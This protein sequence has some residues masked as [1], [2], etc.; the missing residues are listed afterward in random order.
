MWLRLGGFVTMACVAACGG[1]TNSAAP[2]NNGAMPAGPGCEL[3]AP[4]G[5]VILCTEYVGAFSEAGEQSECAGMAAGPTLDSAVP[6]GRWV[7][8]CP[9]GWL[10][11][12]EGALPDSTGA[13]DGGSYVS[14][15]LWHYFENFAC[16]PGWTEIS[17]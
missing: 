14:V 15:I 16:Y 6:D 5:T 1:K 8:S 12:C 3:L 4:N 11:G 10:S 7:T 9:S 17:P 2:P 13:L